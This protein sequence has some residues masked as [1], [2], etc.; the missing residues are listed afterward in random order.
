MRQ[1]SWVG[2]CSIG[3]SHIRAGVGCQDNATCL[4]LALEDGSVLLSVVS[5]GAGSA[6]YSAIGSRLV[7]ECFARSALSH[8]RQRRSTG[9]ITSELVREW[10]DDARNRIFHSA[11]QLGTE[12]RQMAAT[13]VGAIVCSSRAVICHV[14]DGACVLRRDGAS[15]WEVPSWPAHGQYASSTYFV[16]DDPEPR[17]E[18][19]SIEGNFSELAVFSDGLERLALDFGNQTASERFFDPMFAPL[20]NVSPG[21]NRALSASLRRYLDSPRVLERTDDDKSLVLAR[22]VSL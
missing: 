13:L 6:K 17:L 16:T 8:L 18:F 20:V 11:E 4:E 21:R 14:G 15:T 5:D 1:W 3:S 22:R 9:D 7:V 10:M 19:V 12:P 2:A